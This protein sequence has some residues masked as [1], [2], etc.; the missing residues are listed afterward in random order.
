MRSADV[1]LLL[2]VFVIYHHRRGVGILVVGIVVGILSHH[3]ERIPVGRVLLVRPLEEG[4]AVHLTFCP[5]PH[6]VDDS[7]R[8]AAV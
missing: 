5:F 1:G 4:V 6:I 2:A 8:N 7:P 3:A